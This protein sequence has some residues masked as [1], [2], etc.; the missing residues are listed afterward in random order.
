MPFDEWLATLASPGKAHNARAALGIAAALQRLSVEG[1]ALRR[2]TSAPL[3]DGV[4][5]L[6][7]GIGKIN[8]RALYFFAGQGIAVMAHGCTKESAV[9]PADVARAVARRVAFLADPAA[10]TAPAP[11]GNSSFTLTDK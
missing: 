9:H 5:E 2:P 10:H 7:V 11:L 1:H 8:Y 6:R 4:Y 3:R